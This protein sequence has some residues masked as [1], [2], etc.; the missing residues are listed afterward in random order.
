VR[1]LVE[2]FGG[3][4]PGSVSEDGLGWLYGMAY[5]GAGHDVTVITTSGASAAAEAAALA[6]GRSPH[7]VDVPRR[8]WPLRP[9]W[10]V[11]GTAVQYLLWLWD[12]SQAAR[13][14][15]G[16]ARFDVVNHVSYGSI[17]GGTFLWRL[18]RPLVFGPTGGGQTT[19]PAFR[20]LYGSQWLSEAVRSLVITKLWRL[21]WHARQTARRA[22][23]V[24][25][26]NEETMYLARRM[27]ARRVELVQTVP[28]P[29]DFGPTAFPTRDAHDGLHLLWLGRIMPRK[30]AELAVL[31]I[32]GL[33]AE[34]HV[35][36][37]IV[38][39]GANPEMEA[40]FRRWLSN[41]PVAD[42]VTA[43]GQ[44]PFEEVSRAYLAADAFIFTS[45]R[46]TDGVQ[47]LE[48]MAFGL[49][50]ICLDHQ[51]AHLLIPD[52][53][54][55][56]VPVSDIPGTVRDL[57]AAIIKLAG[58]PGGRRAM[59]QVNFVRAQELTWEKKADAVLQVLAE[60]VPGAEGASASSR[61]EDVERYADVN[62]A[63]AASEQDDYTRERYAQFAR[64]IPRGAR[65][66]LDVGCG[67]G[68]G[69]EELLR[70]LPGLEIVGLDAVTTRLPAA[71]ARGYSRTVC[72]SATHIPLED[73]RC[74]AVVA[75]ELIEHLEDSDVDA[76]L[77]DMRRVLRPGGV[78]M[79]TTPNPN[80]LTFRLR[81]RTTLGGNHLSA[82]PPR[83]LRRRLLRLGFSPVKLSGS[84]RMTR[85]VGERFPVL[86]VY[87]SYLVYAV[88][89]G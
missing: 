79:L 87:G 53:G 83:S 85:R 77:A 47:L 5:A 80:G 23:A 4:R 31:A 60:V 65:G 52:D 39:G 75:G 61:A 12:C 51:G 81:G 78:L 13:R 1:I 36:L 14:L 17:L 27:G 82:H 42:R 46:D 19:P 7:F 34:S 2:A 54:G 9:R 74:D 58:D 35:T 30:A 15:D 73:G 66:V 29:A 25:A 41:R 84:G 11:A 50:V 76:A 63:D 32:E 10:T 64:R 16:E 40:S 6:P 69:G 56:K 20:E 89:N 28:L 24:L 57:R 72:A 26:A 37:T 22:A 18:G 38:G 55:I 8:G 3:C 62:A 21:A 71:Q 86:S 88:R 43:L 33:P 49:P 59:A 48:A 44:V 70:S 67:V 68:R 45:V